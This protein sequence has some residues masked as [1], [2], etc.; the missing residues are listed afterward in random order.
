MKPSRRTVSHPKADAPFVELCPTFE[1]ARQ[2][3]LQLSET[4][5]FVR[6]ISMKVE[7]KN[8]M[9]EAV[10]VP[11]GFGHHS[12]DKPKTVFLDKFSRSRGH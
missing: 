2:T 7:A 5:T 11:L 3:L 9:G 8:Y 1:N 6:V 12:R 4:L 10:E